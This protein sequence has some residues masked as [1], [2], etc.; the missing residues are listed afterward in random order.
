MMRFV[1]AAFLG[2]TAFSASAASFDCAKASSRVEMAICASAELSRL[3]EVMA[4]AYAKAFA[5]SADPESVKRGQR[6][7]LLDM[8]NRCQDETCLVAVYRQRTDTLRDSVGG[9]PDEGAVQAAGAHAERLPAGGGVPPHSADA[10]D[11]RDLV[12]LFAR[13][14]AGAITSDAVQMVSA[15]D[16]SKRLSAKALYRQQKAAYPGYYVCFVLDMNEYQGMGS[17]EGEII[18]L[19]EA[20]LQQVMSRF[21]PKE[22][23]GKAQAVRGCATRE[24]ASSP[25]ALA[26]NSWIDVIVVPRQTLP[27]L[28]T[29][30]LQGRNLTP[31]SEKYEQMDVIR[32]KTLVQD[33]QASNTLR[34]SAAESADRRAQR[35][36]ALAAADSREYV[37]SIALTRPSGGNFRWCTLEYDGANAAAVLAYIDR[38]RE[39]LSTAFQANFKERRTYRQAIEGFAS[40]DASY[41]KLQ[42]DPSSCQVYVDFPKNVKL[43][44]AAIERD[45]GGAGYEVNEIVSAQ[46]LRDHWAQKQGWAEWAAMELA[47]AIDASPQQMKMLADR[48]ISGKLGFDAALKEMTAAHYTNSAD[49]GELIAYLDDKKAAGSGQTAL[50]V[51]QA[52]EHAKQEALRAQQLEQAEV[53]A[54]LA[55]LPRPSLA[56]LFDLSVPQ[57]EREFRAGVFVRGKYHAKLTVGMIVNYTINADGTWS[58]STCLP[59]GEVSERTFRN[60]ESGRWTVEQARFTDTG[61][62]Y[63][64]VKF[65]GLRRLLIGRD[66]GIV[67][68]NGAGEAQS[69]TNSGHTT[70]C[71]R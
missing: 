8:R 7:W 36:T 15:L 45:Q 5:S 55:A 10:D 56:E 2:L 71:G 66:A 29:T 47:I 4:A 27:S 26:G 22:L 53:Q 59:Y 41:Q 62:I 43:I 35:L 14:N 58:T 46:E 24:S 68:E 61:K 11:P 19:L 52:R 12:I 38:G 23:L 18:G 17:T 65:N 13:T 20:H 49:I 42:N 34:Q 31:Y 48:G 51:K 54:R 16:G 28:V 63:Y 9:T 39:Y 3:D 50:T 21:A 25:V 40:P 60:T 44:A 6:A 37:A 32:H 33:V 30:D 69:R 67:A 57:A 64:A 1:L 70:D